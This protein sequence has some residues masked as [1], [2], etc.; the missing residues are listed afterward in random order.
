M[1]TALFVKT[2]AAWRLTA[3][4]AGVFTLLLGI[5]MAISH[6]GGKDRDPWRSP[7]LLAQKEQLRNVPKDEAVKKRIRELDLSLRTRY[8]LQLSRMNTGVYLLLG[9]AAAF[10]VAVAR[11]VRG[12]KTLPAL[13]LKPD[14][15]A[16]GRVTVFSRW[17]VAGSGAAVGGFL[18]S[19]SLGFSSGL[20]GTAAQIDKLL[21]GE[22]ESSSGPDA[23]SPAQLASN[24]P[25]F[26]GANAGWAMSSSAPTNWDAVSGANIAWKTPAPAEGF[27]SPIVWSNRVF[28]S[29]GNAALREVFC[30][31]SATGTLLWRQTITNV[32]GAPAKPPEIQEST[33]YA[34][35]TMATDGRLVYVMF[36]NGDLAGLSMDGRVLWAKSFGPLKNTYGHANS[37]TTWRD[38]VIVQ[39]DQG[40]PESNLSKLY[41]FDGRTGRVVWQQS[42]KVGASWAS[43]LAFE[44]NGKGQ[45]VCLSIPWAIGYSA[46]TGAE[47]WRADCLNGEVT[48]TP[49]FSA[50]LILVASPSDKL[51]AYRTDGQGDITKSPVV[52]KSEDNVPDV[53]SPAAT[54]NLVFTMTTSGMLTCY[55]LSDGKKHWEHDFEEEFHASPAIAGQ[56]VY[57]LSQK[58]NAFVIAAAPQFQ[59]V[60]RT[61]MGDSFHASPAI[62]GDRIYLRGMSNIWCLATSPVGAKK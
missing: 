34:A 45:I 6:F 54:T 25:R 40:E 55:Q 39:L 46:E 58:G 60:F 5:T 31:D 59:E 11:T 51:V 53:T 52:W 9:G 50:G 37:L 47:L 8:F 49:V 33:G 10:G 24:W 42:R 29:G 7:Q 57:L 3:W 13:N 41:A 14:A 2:D 61:A 12:R 48:P 26:L 23:A 19:I 38:R 32:P 28:F 30:L 1:N 22:S 17:A 36:A 35:P 4:V 43:P 16:V 44:S 56:H 20:P 62:A 18:F 15:Q 21:N 27:N